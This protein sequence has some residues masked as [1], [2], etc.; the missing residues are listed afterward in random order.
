MKDDYATNSHQLIYTFLFKRSGE[1]KLNFSTVFCRQQ[2]QASPPAAVAL[3]QISADSAHKDLAVWNIMGAMHTAYA[4]NGTWSQHVSNK[5]WRNDHR[6]SVSMWK[7]SAHRLRR[8]FYFAESFDE[9][10]GK[11]AFEMRQ[12]RFS[13]SFRWYAFPNFFY[14]NFSSTCVRRTRLLKS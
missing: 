13:L 7:V 10:S 2:E 6:T 3:T 11:G 14:A 8:T 12:I 4:K 5:T 9:F 1:C